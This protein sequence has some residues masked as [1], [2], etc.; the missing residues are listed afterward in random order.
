M[1]KKWLIATCF[2]ALVLL[3]A[4]CSSKETST[5]KKEPKD[6]TEQETKDK[7]KPEP[8]EPEYAYSF[9]L[10]GIGT[11]EALQSRVVAVMV[12]NAPE[13]R[14]QSGLHK[15]DL[16]YEVLAE[17]RITR[18]VALFQS[19]KPEVI[20]PVRSARDYY[21]RL[22]NGFDAIYVHHGWSPSAK[23]MLTSGNIDSLNGLYY[24]GTLFER[25]SFRKAP[26]N[27]YITYEN[28][29]KESKKRNFELEQ[30]IQAFTFMD[31]KEASSIEGDPAGNLTVTYGKYQVEYQYQE[32]KGIYHRY[33]SKKQTV[34]RETNTPIE[35]ENI[36]VVS[37]D[38]KI[39]DSQGRRSVNL[40]SGGE[41][42][43]FQ[44]GKAK[45]VQWKNDDGR[46]VPVKDGSEVPLVPGKTWV[47]IVPSS[48]FSSKVTWE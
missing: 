5:E 24:D 48:D 6:K 19:E 36:F 35:L 12:N 1:N 30:E 33:T 25:V 28:I 8:E 4:A 27:S 7:E 45:Q 40:T 18:L 43:L 32:D 38:H 34:D 39:L 47:N 46:I 29:L 9:P 26:H 22:S 42:I 44:E 37:T 10:T 13:A 16:V 21:V 11:D 31:E 23:T 41:A 14:P 20:G 17:G 15:A 2:V 3:F